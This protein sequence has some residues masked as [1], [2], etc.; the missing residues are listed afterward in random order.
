MYDGTGFLGFGSA[1]KR[2]QNQSLE[3]C[4]GDFFVDRGGDHTMRSKM[5]MFTLFFVHVVLQSRVETYKQ[6]CMYKAS[7]HPT[8]S[9]I[10]I[11]FST[12]IP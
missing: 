10:L 12:R 2:A 4:S 3:A 8:T 11:H 9:T 5:L 6:I 1:L 7:E